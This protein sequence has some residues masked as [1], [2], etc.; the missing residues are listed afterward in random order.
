MALSNFQIIALNCR[1]EINLL[2]RYTLDIIKEAVKNKYKRIAKNS[3]RFGHNVPSH[4]YIM[5]NRCLFVCPLAPM[6]WLKAKSVDQTGAPEG[7]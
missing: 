6:I 3:S 5:T 2:A 7:I 4:I 1:P